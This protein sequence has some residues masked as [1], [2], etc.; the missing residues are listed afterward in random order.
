MAANDSHLIVC[1]TSLTCA[2]TGTY[3]TL[4]SLKNVR[5]EIHVDFISFVTFPAAATVWTT[6]WWCGDLFS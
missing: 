6:S 4:P 2:C 1:C 5:E 3:F